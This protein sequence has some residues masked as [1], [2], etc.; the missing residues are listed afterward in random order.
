MTVVTRFAPSPTG[1]LHIGGARTA[2]FNYLF[3]KHHGGKYLLRVEDTDKKRST[4]DAKD[5]IID[6]LGWLGL[7]PDDDN[8]IVYQ[9]QNAQRHAQIAHDLVASGHAY[10]CYCSPEDL[11]QMRSEAKIQGRATSYDRRW[12]DRDPSQA[13][14][15][16]KPVI[17]IKMPTQGETV[18]TDLVQGP[19][20]MPNEQLDDFIIL[21]ADGTPT[22]MLSVVVDDHDMA[23]THIIRGDDH[24][25][26]AFRQYHLYKACGWDIP[27]FAHIPLIYGPDGKKLSKRHGAIAV[28]VYRDDMGYLA[29]AVFNYLLRLGWSHG[30]DEIISH[31]QAIDWFGL[32]NVGKSP[33]RFDFD[34]LANVN[35]HYLKNSD[36][37][38]L[39]SL[40]L[41]KLG[42]NLD[43]PINDM[44]KDRLLRG[45]DSM[46]DRVKTI[47]ELADY[48]QFYIHD[49]QYPLQGK[50]VKMMNE[51]SKFLCAEIADHLESITPWDEETIG[52]AL[53]AFAEQK[54]LGFGKIGQPTRAAV[55]GTPKSPDL[56]QMLGVFGK[57][58]VVK[59]LRAVPQNPIE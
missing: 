45:M 3:A 32:D 18:L 4:D 47:A 49:V 22:Y 48:C 12:R 42:Q 46:K 57:D 50:A 39:L 6:G 17:R 59:R 54:D 24:L 29:D 7:L 1:F 52:H 27:E 20:T 56:A 35:A 31:S 16:V 14:T 37:E 58:E 26:N 43:T 36:N 9:S 5:A 34:K 23:V 30:D 53:K 28:D 13:P 44:A 11:E 51:D 10:Y 40:L 38:T 15:D 41:A 2:L 19:V 33:S 21:R 25:I 8:P 55:S